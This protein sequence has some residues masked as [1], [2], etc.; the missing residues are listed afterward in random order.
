MDSLM[1]CFQIL[2]QQQHC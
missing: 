2:S 1:A